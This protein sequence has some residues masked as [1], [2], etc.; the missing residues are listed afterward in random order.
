MITVELK[1]ILYYNNTRD[2]KPQAFHLT[3]LQY[4]GPQ[5]HLLAHP[6]TSTEDTKTTP[7]LLLAHQVIPCFNGPQPHLLAHRAIPYILIKRIHPLDTPQPTLVVAVCPGV[8]P[9]TPP[10]IASRVRSGGAPG[11][12]P[13]P[14]FGTG[15]HPTQEGWWG[16]DMVLLFGRSCDK[17]I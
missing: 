6:P 2:K 16:Q 8:S 4:N 17:A 12:R 11:A 13:T 10:D 9:Q 14:G 3:P 5:P 1:S 7:K 15:R